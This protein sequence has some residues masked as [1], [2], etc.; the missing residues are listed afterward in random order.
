MIE[1]RLQ[2]IFR[3][4]KS[5]ELV[6][7]YFSPYSSKHDVYNDPILFLYLKTLEKYGEKHHRR[8]TCS[9]MVFYLDKNEKVHSKT[10]GDK[11]LPSKENLLK[12]IVKGITH[13]VIFPLNPCHAPCVFKQ[14]C[15]PWTK[16]II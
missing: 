9:I 10:F 11:E 8:N 16:Q 15:F 3:K 14:K 5:K 2:S 13:N 4:R 7:L 12:S 6:G 1:L